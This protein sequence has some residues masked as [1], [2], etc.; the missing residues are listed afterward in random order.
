MT[1]D[2]ASKPPLTPGQIQRNR[3]LLIG[4]LLLSLAPLLAA[5][6][7]YFGTPDRIAGAQT[8]RG[9]LLSPPADLEAL[10]LRDEQGQLLTTGSQRLWRVM[11]FTGEHCDD[12]CVAAIKLLRQVHVLLGRDEDRVQRYA[13]LPETDSAS[14]LRGTL[15]RELPE[16]K[17]LQAPAGLLAE[18]LE[19]RALQGRTLPDVGQGQ[20]N[21]GVLVVDPLG[22]V[23]FYHGLE[24]IG[25]PLLSD[26]KQLLRLSNIG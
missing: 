16:M 19:A 4:L 9:A 1:D 2:N 17:L 26:L 7:L 10:Q 23:I 21:Q 20:P 6:W 13:V 5:L 14:R 22:N 8:N 12:D 15:R 11:V 25:E 24:Q 18:T 3:W